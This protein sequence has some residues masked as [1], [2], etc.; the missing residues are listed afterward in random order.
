MNH[1]QQ[2]SIG[3]YGR[4]H[5][6]AQHQSQ[7]SISKE[8]ASAL[9]KLKKT[10][11]FDVFQV[12]DEVTLAAQ[13][14][15]GVAQIDN[16]TVEVLPKIDGISEQKVRQNLVGML[17][18][19]LDLKISEGD[20]ASVSTQTNGVLEVFV[21]LF[22]NKLYEQV[23]RGLV[24]RYE[25]KQ[26]NLP[27]LRGRLSVPEQIRLN[28]AAPE[29]LYCRFEEFQDDNPLNQIL[30]AAIR[31]LLKLS[32]DLANHRRLSELLL[33]FESVVDINRASLPWHRISIDRLDERYLP[34]FKLAELFL[35]QK[36]IM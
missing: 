11:G 27:F 1:R 25:S 35:M 29:R 17:S 4:L 31:F 18:V 3:E 5:V 2:I 16:L 28:A 10:H 8:Q 14:Y 21:R 20:I 15:V 34:S 6:G 12:V 33:M 32:R 22:C 23:R 24:R 19:A 26:E 13:Q 7:P 30:K 36:I 9:R